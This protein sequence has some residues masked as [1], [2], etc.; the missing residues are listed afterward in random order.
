[1]RLVGIAET[2]IHILQHSLTKDPWLHSRC[3]KKIVFDE[4]PNILM[5]WFF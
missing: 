5:Y 1:M 4:N 2:I 3:I